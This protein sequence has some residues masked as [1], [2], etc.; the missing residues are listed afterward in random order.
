MMSDDLSIFVSFDMCNLG[1]DTAA[2]AVVAQPV[3]SDWRHQVKV[4]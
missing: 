1:L 4:L 3:N 2:A